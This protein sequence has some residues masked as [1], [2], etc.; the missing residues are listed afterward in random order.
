M[1]QIVSKGMQ[2]SLCPKMD[3]CSQK[4]QASNFIT[5]KLMILKICLPLTALGIVNDLH[6]FIS[7]LSEK[8]STLCEML[9]TDTQWSWDAPHQKSFEPLELYISN[10]QSL[11]ISLILQRL[12]TWHMP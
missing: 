4:R 12:F 7:N 3:I 1:L 10:P 2:I 6:K 8:T 5:P 11:Y 9:R